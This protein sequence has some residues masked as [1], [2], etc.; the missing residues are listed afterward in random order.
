MVERIDAQQCS[1]R[2]TIDV[3]S[4]A[5]VSAARQAGKVVSR[6]AGLDEKALEE[7]A[8]AVTELAT[9]LVKHARAGHMIFT[10]VH[11]SGRSGIQIESIDSGPGIPDVN[12]VV[13]DG[14]STARSLGYGLG[15]V[16]RLMDEFTIVS[17]RKHGKGVHLT[18]KRW[19]QA[20]SCADM[21]CPLEFGVATRPHPRE[22]LNGDTFVTKRSAATALVGVIDGLGHGQLAHRSA[23]TARLYVE[24]HAQQPLEA[25]FRGANY[26]CRSSNGVVMALA[27][28]AF[29]R[30]RM[31]FASVGNIESRVFGTKEKIDFI[32]RR[33]VVGLN[34]P[35]AFVTEHPWRPASTLVLHS[36]GLKTSWSWD[37]FPTA[38]ELSAD[39]LAR[40]LLRRLGRDDDDATVL[41]VKYSAGRRCGD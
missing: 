15:A 10:M 34:A 1:A 4:D 39:A 26:A 28:F 20:D 38:Q 21:V 13:A 25:I 17:P 8:I 2:E 32:V 7:V 33:G 37:E 6:A 35:E 29:R 22:T 30:D 19:K 31:S 23:S 18:C 3:S 12:R 9:N 41:V 24:N 16:N 27:R 14:Y 11:E 36:D 5:D 40:L